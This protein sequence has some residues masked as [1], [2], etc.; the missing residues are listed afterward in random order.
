[1]WS[2][3]KQLSTNCK[4]PQYQLKPSPN[5]LFLIISPRLLQNKCDIPRK[6]LNYGAGKGVALNRHFK[7]YVNMHRDLILP[8]NA[9]CRVGSAT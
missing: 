9:S 8:E 2:L 1:M 3:R 6:L 5:C 4:K 7:E